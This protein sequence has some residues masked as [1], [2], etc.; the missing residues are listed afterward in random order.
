MP[1]EIPRFLILTPAIMV[2]PGLVTLSLSTPGRIPVSLT[3]VAVLNTI[4]L[5]D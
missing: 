4:D 1:N 3:R 2:P 5:I